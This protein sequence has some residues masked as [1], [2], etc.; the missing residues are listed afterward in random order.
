MADF[1]DFSDFKVSGAFDGVKSTDF[2][3]ALPEIP[4]YNIAP[5]STYGGIFLDLPKTAPD[6]TSW[7]GG[8]GD[9]FSGVGSSVSEVSKSAVDSI[10]NWFT[11][12]S[13]GNQSVV[14]KAA[15]VT[16]AGTSLYSTVSG[17]FKGGN[18]APGANKATV[19]TQGTA[20]GKPVQGLGVIGA[21]KALIGVGPAPQGSTTISQAVGQGAS[22]I[23]TGVVGPLMPTLFLILAGLLIFWMILGRMQRA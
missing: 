10:G 11:T 8:V 1:F 19:A 22:N 23:V 21:L 4:T 7:L 13:N 15:G 12:P 6:S 9:W 17:W 20:S 2:L 16:T 18:A 5:T 3:E 14:Q